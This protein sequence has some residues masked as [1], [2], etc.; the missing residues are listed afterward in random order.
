MS[1]SADEEA[2]GT[3]GNNQVEEDQKY[4]AKIGLIAT[5]SRIAGLERCIKSVYCK[6]KTSS[7]DRET[8][9]SV[10]AAVKSAIADSNQGT[11]DSKWSSSLSVSL[12]P[13]AQNNSKLRNRLTNFGWTGTQFRT[14]PNLEELLSTLEAKAADEK[15]EAEEKV[16]KEREK[17]EAKKELGRRVWGRGGYRNALVDDMGQHGVTLQKRPTPDEIRKGIDTY[18]RSHHRVVVQRDEEQIHNMI[19]DC[20]SKSVK[21]S[22]RKM[23]QNLFQRRINLAIH[24]RL[25]NEWTLP[26]IKAELRRR[27]GRDESRMARPRHTV[28]ETNPGRSANAESGSFDLMNETV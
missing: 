5:E 23:R 4:C 25:I 16:L 12:R 8:L 19:D 1:S 21:K 14:P 2:L 7:L 27:G 18:R 6:G 10:V 11:L 17:E 15:V 9:V 24:D 20:V 13:L 26:K 22:L 28:A 3:F